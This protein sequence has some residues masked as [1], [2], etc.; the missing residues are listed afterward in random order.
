[1]GDFNVIVDFSDKME[2][3]DKSAIEEFK[4]CILDAAWLTFHPSAANIPEL[5]EG[6]ATDGL[7]KN[8]FDVMPLRIGRP[9]PIILNLILKAQD[10][11]WLLPWNT[12][13][14]TWTEFGLKPFGFMKGWIN[15]PEVTCFL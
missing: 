3:V 8:W 4:K 9:C 6:W 12:H 15:W 14:E 1:M 11:R 2:V 5:Q 7:Q 13:S 10:F